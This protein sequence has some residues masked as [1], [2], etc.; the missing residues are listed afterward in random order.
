MKNIANLFLYISVIII[1][2]LLCNKIGV[3][4]KKI[5]NKNDELFL[6]ERNNIPKGH[7]LNQF[8]YESVPE[9]TT[10]YDLNK[11]F[12]Q[13]LISGA[14]IHP[15]YANNTFYD[16][17]V[18]HD[19]RM[20]MKPVHETRIV[21]VIPNEYPKTIKY[22][23]DGSITDFKKITPKKKGKTGTFDIEGN[24]GHKTYIPDF[25]SY[26]N[27]KPENGGKYDKLSY[28]LHGY[29][30]LIATDNTLF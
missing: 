2:I 4:N 13:E 30:P 18:I 19:N 25:I 22:I 15:Q 8:D 21:P 28:T 11:N 26:N 23:Y 29:D 17:K 5:L 1:L 3:T 16:Q 6:Q 27:E 14:S 9:D 20:Y 7:V 12:N 24:F 10:V